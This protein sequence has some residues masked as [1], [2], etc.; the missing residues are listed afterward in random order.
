MGSLPKN[1]A[2]VN[3][4]T[5]RGLSGMSR[6]QLVEELGYRGVSLP[7]TSLSRIENGEQAVKIEEAIAFADIFEVPLEGFLLEPIGDSEYQVNLARYNEA[8]RNL[9]A[10]LKDIDYEWSSAFKS[11]ELIRELSG[12][13]SDPSTKEIF[14]K[15]GYIFEEADESINRLGWVESMFQINE[16]NGSS[17]INRN[18]SRP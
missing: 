11:I 16:L 5:L 6:R 1:W 13:V 10:S 8:K 14:E 18:V 12:Q 15:F 4:K 3:V 17:R 2:N 9:I 7:Q